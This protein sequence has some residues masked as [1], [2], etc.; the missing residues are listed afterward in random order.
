MRV[1]GA[2][3]LIVLTFA[4]VTAFVIDRNFGGL[5][6]VPVFPTPRSR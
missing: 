3:A 2:V 5:V 6:P 4:L 1:G